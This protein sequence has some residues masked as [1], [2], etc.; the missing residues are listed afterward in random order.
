MGKKLEEISWQAPGKLF[1]LLAG[2]EKESVLKRELRS[3]SVTK[4]SERKAWSISPSRLREFQKEDWKTI[5]TRPRTR[6]STHPSHKV[7]LS[8]LPCWRG[9]IVSQ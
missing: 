1:F 9:R 6:P 2:R 8:I 3:L 7:P 5:R 4:E